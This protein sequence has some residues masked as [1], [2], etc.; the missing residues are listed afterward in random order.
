MDLVACRLVD[1]ETD[2]LDLADVVEANDPDECV[3]VF[4]L[5]LLD[6]SSHL[7]GVCAPKHGQL[8]HGPVASI[9]VSW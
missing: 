4:L 3:G 7:S 1:N 8:P 2:A 9:V 5:G 6:L